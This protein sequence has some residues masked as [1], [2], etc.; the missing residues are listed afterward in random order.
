MY[1]YLANCKTFYVSLIFLDDELCSDSFPVK[2]V[3]DVIYEF[4]GKVII[5]IR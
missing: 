2:V 3:D 4:K 5:I 1:A